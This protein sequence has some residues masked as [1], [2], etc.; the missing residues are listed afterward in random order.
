VHRDF[1]ADQIIVSA[2]R[3]W[4]IDF[5]LYC[6]GDPG[7]DVGNFLGHLTEQSLRTLGDPRGLAPLERAMAERF[8]LL[9]GPV[10]A[11]AAAT[12][13]TLTLARHVY[14]S[15]LFVERQP[16]TY[17]ILELCEERLGEQLS[18]LG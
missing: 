12:Y 2:K 10:A 17:R 16:Y 8:A 4:L 14:L 15:T 9:S 3:V 11:R 5:D 1:Y 6:N 7:L 13:A 18:M